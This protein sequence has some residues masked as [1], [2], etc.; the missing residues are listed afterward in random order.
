MNGDL[1]ADERRCRIV[2]SDGSVD[3]LFALQLQKTDLA[4][5]QSDAE[6]DAFFGIG[7]A[8][9]KPM[10]DLRSLFSLYVE[11]VAILVRADAGISEFSDL[12]GKTLNA[13]TPG[14]GSFKTF[15]TL[16]RAHDFDLDD[17]YLLDNRPSSEAVEALCLRELDAV[18][19]V[20]GHPNALI[21]RATETC[22]LRMMPL[23][24][25]NTEELAKNRS[26]FV[27]VS[28]PGGLYRGIDYDVTTIGT[29][30]NL[31]SRDDLPEDLAYRL[32]RTVFSDWANFIREHPALDTF[33]DQI[34]PGPE[35]SRI[36]PI[37][38]G[39]ERFFREQGRLEE[40]NKP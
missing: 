22:D 19:Y 35:K 10:T 5:V 40:S 39:A 7:S 31:V 12:S 36:V 30:A 1:D 9:M 26:Y 3:N 15:Q 29:Q 16:A 2:E 17:L 32:T 25:E 11:A 34:A 27:N 37:H 24:P 8:D 4:I 20:S 21:A 23:S 13:G 28:I 18:L 38:P 6:H 33:S 14:S